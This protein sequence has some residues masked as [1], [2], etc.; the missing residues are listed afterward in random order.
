MNVLTIRKVGVAEKADDVLSVGIAEQEDGGGTCLVFS[1]SL[2][3]PTEQDIALGLETYSISNELG[4]T[5]YGG[6]T[7]E[8]SATTLTIRF[9]GNAARDLDLPRTLVLDLLVGREAIAELAAGLRVIF[10]QSASETACDVP[11]A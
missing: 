7:Y 8:L 9:T 6:A 4:A 11:T 10:D 2:G 3:P 1:R 5:T